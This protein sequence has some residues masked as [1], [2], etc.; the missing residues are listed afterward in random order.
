MSKRKAPEAGNPNQDFC[1]F[2]FELANFEKNVN[3][4]VHKHNAYRKAAGVLSKLPERIKSGAEAK[5]LEGIGTKISEKIDEFIATGKLRKLDKIRNEPE[6]N[7]INELTRVAGI[8]PAKARELVDA[9]YSSIQDL[10]DNPEGLSKAQKIGLKHF[11]DFELRISRDE[12][13]EVETLLKSEFAKI[14]VKLRGTICG[15]Y[16]RGL[17]SSGDIDVLLTHEDYQSGSE[18]KS[19]LK[20]VV[21]A[22]E[23]IELITDTISLGDT[24]FMGVCKLKKHFRRLDIRLLPRDQYYCGVLYFTGSDMFNK[25]MRSHALDIGFTLNEYTI[26]PLDAGMVPM[27]PLPVSS[28]EDIFDYLSMEFKHPYERST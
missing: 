24:K 9:G 7:A 10:R 26:R 8:G 18:G 6:S 20:K 15:S 2:L 4:N 21:H 14:D 11:E 19:H 23:K 22:L 27:Q 5:K 28:E 1:D 17:A 12:I 13:S 16:R 25:N 3:R